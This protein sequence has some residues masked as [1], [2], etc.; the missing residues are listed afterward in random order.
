MGDDE[1]IIFWEPVTY[2]YFVNSEPNP[3]LDTVLDNFMKSQNYTLFLPILKQV[4]GDLA[5]DAEKLLQDEKWLKSEVERVA[6]KISSAA[7]SR[8]FSEPDLAR[9]PS[10]LGPGFTAPPGGADY[11]NR[12]VMSYHYYCWALG[13]SSDQEFDPVLRTVCDE[14]LGPMVFNTVSAR[15]AELGG[16]G[17]MLTEFGECTPSY[18]HP[19][20]Q[21]TIECNTVLD[22]ADRHLQSWSYWDTASGGVFWSGDEVNLEAVKVFSRPYPPATAGT[23]V[24][25]QYD[26]A[27]RVMEF[28]YQPNLQILS[29]TELYIPGLIYPAGYTVSCSP[30]LVWDH[31]PANPNMIL[32]TAFGEEMATVTITPL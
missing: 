27:T 8:P 7:L 17:T 5:E 16:S 11:L 3:I 19:D 10:V 12:T 31:D 28:S 26:T 13:Y 6:N 9:H 15:A 24:S 30:Q 1:T 22:E 29:P 23:P 2:A 18:S 32:V 4:C 21:G 14:V 25:L 20:Y